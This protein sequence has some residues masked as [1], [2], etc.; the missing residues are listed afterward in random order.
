[1]PRHIFAFNDQSATDPQFIGCLY[2]VISS[3]DISNAEPE[4]TSY[5]EDGVSTGDHILILAGRL[6]FGRTLC[7]PLRPAV[8]RWS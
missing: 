3:I 5:A 2:G 4:A 6:G 7:V 8:V 1:V